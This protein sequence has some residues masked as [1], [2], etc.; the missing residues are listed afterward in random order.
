MC[1]KWR[2]SSDPAAITGALR[3]P[4]P[5]QLY[6]L[7][8]STNTGEKELMLRV[9]E[10]EIHESIAVTVYEHPVHGDGIDSLTVGQRNTTDALQGVSKVYLQEGGNTTTAE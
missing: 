6:I 3:R 1:W 5:A 2:V 4:N 7:P 9:V 10:D 8:S